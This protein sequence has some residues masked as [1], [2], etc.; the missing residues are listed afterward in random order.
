MRV[1]LVMGLTVNVAVDEAYEFMKSLADS[2]DA[3][4]QTVLRWLA[5]RL[6]AAP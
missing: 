6:E 3:S 2:G 5:D 1:L 4:G